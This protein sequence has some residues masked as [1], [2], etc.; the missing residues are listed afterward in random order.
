MRR[1]GSDSRRNKNRLTGN[2]AGFLLLL[3]CLLAAFVAWLCWRGIQS[4]QT[5]RNRFTRYDEIIRQAGLRNGVDPALLKAVIWRESK[6]D[7]FTIGSRG[8]IGLMQLMPNYSPA[9]WAAAHKRATP[10][11]GAL[12]DPELNI[13]IGSWFLGR[14][15]RRWSSYKD[16][17]IL[18][19]CEY[20][21]GFQRADAWKPPQKSGSMKDRIG[22]RTTRV[23][24]QS[25]LEKQKEY[26]REF[27]S[28]KKER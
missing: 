27:R 18:A 2:Q 14:A 26:D 7:R 16:G 15:L 25:I 11:P 20:N 10:S 1:K 3:I 8:E 4:Y 12:S 17:V 9:D 24:V 19:L 23:Y 22:I 21:A 6:F 13:E 5:Y 28:E